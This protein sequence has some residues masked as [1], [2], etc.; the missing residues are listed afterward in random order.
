[1]EPDVYIP[2]EEIDLTLGWKVN[3]RKKPAFRTATSM[4]TA[5]FYSLK[6]AD[7]IN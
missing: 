1:M 2:A 5:G 6:K 3:L 4:R 7:E